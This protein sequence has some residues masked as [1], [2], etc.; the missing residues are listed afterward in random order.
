[1]EQ[2]KRHEY[3]LGSTEFAT[4]K[5]AILFNNDQDGFF[6][7][8]VFIFPLGYITFHSLCRSSSHKIIEGLSHAF[9]MITDLLFLF[10]GYSCSNVFKLISVFLISL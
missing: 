10:S 3:P 1:M 4:R 9:R 7:L 2:N 5:E 8:L 6:A